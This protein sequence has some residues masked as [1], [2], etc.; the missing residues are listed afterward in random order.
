[1]GQARE[2]MDRI[3]AAL[4]AGDADELGRL[5]AHDAVLDTPDEG[6]I[7][8]R[9]GVVE[10]LMGFLRAFPD[11]TFELPTQLEAGDTAVD[12]GHLVATHTGPLA[13]PDGDELPATGR[14]IRL[15]ECD[16]LTVAGGVAVSHALYF[17]QLDFLVQLGL[18]DPASI[19][20]QPQPA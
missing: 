3:T 17:D 13:L 8:G 7:E 10:Y 2:I 20:Q 18:V 5:Y 11:T 6:R 15:R 16:V 12:R 4:S 14:R 19:G 1:M 9:A